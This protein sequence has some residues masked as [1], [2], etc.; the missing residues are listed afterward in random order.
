MVVCY[1][2][3]SESCFCCHQTSEDVDNGTRDSYILELFWIA[4]W[5]VGYAE[6]PGEGLRSEEPVRAPVHEIAPPS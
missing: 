2:N 4:V 1:Q 6:V 3:N 5:G